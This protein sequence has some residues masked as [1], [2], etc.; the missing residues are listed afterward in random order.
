MPQAVTA[1]EAPNDI[2]H[3]TGA[4]PPT[5]GPVAE[6]GILQATGDFEGAVGTAGLNGAV[7]LAVADQ[8]TFN[9]IYLIDIETSSNI[10]YEYTFQRAGAMALKQQVFVTLLTT[11]LGISLTI[12]FF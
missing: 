5:S 4:F 3:L 7:N 1:A 10:D 9:C 2:T 12:K 6:F 8:I 11:L